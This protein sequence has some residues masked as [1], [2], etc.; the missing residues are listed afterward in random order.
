MR[1]ATFN[2]QNLRLRRI[3]G[4]A[5]LDGAVDGDMFQPGR[6]PTMDIADRWQTARVIQE[7]RADIM[8]LQEVFDLA[9]LDH[10]HDRFLRR[11]GGPAY[12][13]RI[14]RPGNDGRGLNVAAMS[15][16]APA[17]VRSHAHVTGGDLGLT[18]LPEALRDLPIFRRDCLELEF[19][20]LTIFVCHFKAPYPD[21]Q[22]AH[23]VREAE[24]RA[25]RRIIER[26]FDRPDQARWIAL[27]D[28]N[29]PAP[30]QEPGPSALAPLISDFAVDLMDRRR[31]GDRW[32][33]E[34]A[35][36]HLH[37]RPDR[38]LVSPRLAEEY[39]AVR[40][41]II[42]ASMGLTG[43]DAAIARRPH[44]SDH[45]LVHVDFAGL[46]DPAT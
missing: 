39:P 13:V 27:G 6:S 37:S 15:R 32:T 24:A 34:V 40:P 2:L 4:R 44:A 12:P 29:E 17:T 36:T 26:R 35:G 14:C 3:D 30:G 8:A 45:A 20:G 33:Y 31:P 25:V 1:I 10:L 7:A 21:A 46:L 11:I 43:D 28:F 38:I 5:H 22:K 41:G 23:L 16:I 18:D 19:G 42:R 9:A